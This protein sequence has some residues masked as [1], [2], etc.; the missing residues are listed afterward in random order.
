MLWAPPNSFLFWG[1]KSYAFLLAILVGVFI[2]SAQVLTFL[3]QYSLFIMLFY[4][5]LNMEVNREMMSLGHLKI[6]AANLLFPLL[7]FLAFRQIN[8][9]LALAGFMIAIAPTA[10]A[11]PVITNFLKGRV[12]YVTTSVL[13]NSIVVALLIPFLLPRLVEVNQPISVLNVLVPVAILV[14]V[15]LILGQLIQHRVKRLH[16]FLNKGKDIPFYLFVMNVFIAS[17]K[18]SY[19][20]QNDA[21]TELNLIL[22]IAG[23]T[24]FICIINFGMGHL[25]GKPKFP[26]EGSM[27]LGR[28]NTMFS[29]WLALTFVNP[30]TALA[31][32]F[33]IL[34]QNLYNSFQLIQMERKS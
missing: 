19:F 3:I 32:I 7:I 13:L 12:A 4:A 24:L 8:L 30:L 6:A 31:P 2:P 9:T 17:A 11:A 14:F 15:P 5:F 27:S 16:Q 20:I 34:F 18:S 23:L 10:A 21:S 25:F 28:K 33:Y 26:L 29:L 1:V 22:Q